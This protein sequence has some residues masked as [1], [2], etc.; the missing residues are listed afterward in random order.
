MLLLA[1]ALTT[2]RGVTARACLK[3][4]LRFSCFSSGFR[5]FLRFGRSCIQKGA[6][7]LIKISARGRCAQEHRTFIKQSVVSCQTQSFVL[8]RKN[9]GGRRAQ[10]HRTFVRISAETEDQARLEIEDQAQEIP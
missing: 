8:R 5:R 2:A 1:A 3:F 10:E 9:A 7:F 6:Q 4:F